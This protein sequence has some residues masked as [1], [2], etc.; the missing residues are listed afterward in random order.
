MGFLIR[1]LVTALALWAAA[2]VVDGVRLTESLVGVAL[3]AL[4]FG[5]VNAVIRPIVKFFSFPLVILTLGL[6]VLV[7]NA[8]ML[9]LTAGVTPWLE[10]AGFGAAFWGALVIAVVSFVANLVVGDGKKATK[11]E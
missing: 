3:V 8:L 10:V 7:I 2:W 1:L 9:W 11:K 6:F 4:V 5:L